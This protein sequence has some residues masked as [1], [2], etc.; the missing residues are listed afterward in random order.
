[1]KVAVLMGGASFERET[2]LAS[3]KVVCEALEEAGHKVV[4]L[5]TTKELVPT[6]RGE[7]PDI[8]Y[9]ALHGKH[10]EDGTIQSLLDF[11]DIPYVGSPAEVCRNTFNKALLPASVQKFRRYAG[12]SGPGWW[13]QGFC[14]A[15]DVFKDMGAATALDLV[16]ERIPGGYPVCVKPARGGSAYGVHK[17]ERQEDLGAAIL[18]ALTFDSEVLIEQ[19]IDGIELSVAIL[20]NGWDATA[21]PPV[22]IV[23]RSGLFLTEE[24]F[25]DDAVDYYTP[26]RL[27]SLH[28]D[29]SLAQSIRS[30]IERAAIEVYQAF[31][32]QDL[33]RVDLIW[34]GAQARILEVNVS[35]G[36]TEHSLF[37]MACKAAGLSLPA[38][39]DRLVTRPR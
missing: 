13:P 18:D 38:V 5:D 39:L 15:G 2:S 20:G 10:G 27:E 30:E 35:P 11:L 37:P 29:P 16:G 1:M 26:V 12:E 19:W 24:R 34:D 33:G 14:L 4:P 22:E 8:C 25:D 9:I 6:L 17:V 31:N 28:A 23:S 36:M 7:R 21:L 3:G 32:V